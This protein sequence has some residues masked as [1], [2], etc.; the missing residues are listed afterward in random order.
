MCVFRIGFIFIDAPRIGELNVKLN[1][2]TSEN[3][4]SNKV[5]SI[6]ILD[7]YAEA[8]NEF[9][10]TVA[11]LLLLHD[12]VTSKKCLNGGQPSRKLCPI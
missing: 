10:G 5:K 11:A 12:T 1:K 7:V 6:V 8:Y 3:V 4:A 2:N 9:A